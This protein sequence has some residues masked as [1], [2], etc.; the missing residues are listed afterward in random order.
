MASTVT[1]KDLTVT[2]MESYSLNGTTYDSSTPI[3]FSSQGKVDKRIM[4]ITQADDFSTET[5]IIGTASADAKGTI[6]NGDWAYF[7]VTNLDDTN[8][9]TLKILSNATNEAFFKLEAGESFL[10][11]SP[12]I[13]V[14]CA[15]TD[16]VS[17][18]DIT[19]VNAIA[20]TAP[21]DIEYFV[22]TL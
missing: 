17:L 18:A 21:I 19:E 6:I 15:D 3:T 1:A 11:M 7:R 10:L 2:I 20:N 4:E 8:F 16:I 5:T 13:D 22:V 12:D 9:I 14:D